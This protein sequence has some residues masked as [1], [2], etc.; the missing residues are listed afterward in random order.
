VSAVPLAAR[1]TS[2]RLR[3]ATVHLK[4]AAVREEAK[5]EM[6]RRLWVATAIASLA[7]VMVGFAIGRSRPRRSQLFGGRR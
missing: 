4:V 1:M 6:D 7:A 2:D 3:D 5:R